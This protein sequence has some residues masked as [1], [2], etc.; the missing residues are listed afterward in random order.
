MGH[1]LVPGCLPSVEYSLPFLVLAVSDYADSL[2]DDEVDEGD[3]QAGG[4][5]KDKK[6][7]PWQ[8]ERA[9]L[10]EAYQWTIRPDELDEKDVAALKEPLYLL[11]V[12]RVMQKAGKDLNTVA[13]NELPILELVHALE[14]WRD[15]KP[16]LR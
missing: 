5:Q 14:R 7:I 9:L 12:F 11:R 4:K 15:G 10:C 13:E 3:L 1:G 6:P 2:F 8:L 16:P